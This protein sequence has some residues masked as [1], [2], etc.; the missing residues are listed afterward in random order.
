[1][2]EAVISLHKKEQKHLLLKRL[3]LPRNYLK[4]SNAPKNEMRF[5]FSNL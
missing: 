5:S 4:S 2:S 1:M 3:K